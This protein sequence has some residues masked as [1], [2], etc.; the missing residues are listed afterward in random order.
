MSARL[1]AVSVRILPYFQEEMMIQ[2]DSNKLEKKI[3][4][5]REEKETDQEKLVN[6]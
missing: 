3:I 6:L 4:V 1:K 2:E 5:W